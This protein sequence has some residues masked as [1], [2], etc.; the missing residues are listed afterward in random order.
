M[1]RRTNGLS[2]V[3]AVTIIFCCVGLKASAQNAQAMGAA[4]PAMGTQN[5]SQEN[6]AAKSS[7]ENFSKARESFLKKDYKAAAGEIRKSIKFMKSEE[8]HAGANGKKLLKSS[9]KELT[10][11][12]KDIEKG[13]VTTVQTLDNAFSRAKNA[14]AKNRQ[15]NAVE[16]DTR[17]AVAKT[18]HALKDASS[19]VK[20]GLSWTGD[21]IGTAA[22]VVVKDAGFVAGKVIEGGGWVGERTGDA[23]NAVGVTIKNF[24][25]KLQPKK[26]ETMT[27]SAQPV[28]SEEITVSQK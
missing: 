17:R 4:K 20:H 3:S 28:K 5:A 19:N 1:Y 23:V 24:G 18:G 27:Q 14:I 2:I 25:R 16:S 7:E 12:T 13:T 26:E 10:R 8:A 9:E 11:L 6:A 22:S 21:K 15:M